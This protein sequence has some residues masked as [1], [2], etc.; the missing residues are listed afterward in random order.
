MSE[1][2]PT[3]SQLDAILFPPRLQFYIQLYKRNPKSA[4]Q[5]LFLVQICNGSFQV[6]HYGHYV[7]FCKKILNVFL[8][9]FF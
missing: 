6:I 3:K 7:M 1:I 4:E 5:A 2:F 8:S 9:G